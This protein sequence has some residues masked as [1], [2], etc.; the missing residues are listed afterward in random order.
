[1][2]R[3][4]RSGYTLLEILIV[5]AVLVILGAAVVP[6]MDSYRGNTRQKSAADGIR[7]RLADARSLAMERGTWYRLALSTDKTRIRLAPDGPDF[8]SLAA[9]VP[10]AINSPVTEDQFEE[11]VTAELR[12]DSDDMQPATSGEWITIVTVGPDGTCREDAVTV[13]VKEKD[14]K[15]IELRVSGLTGTARFIKRT[16]SQK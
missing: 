12:L 3:N 10:P 5:L 11:G 1:M 9:D 8:G 7:A 13:V 16:G 2:P 15:P 6:T 14:F 4:S